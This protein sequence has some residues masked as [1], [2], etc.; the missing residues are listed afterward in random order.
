M[1]ADL[2]PFLDL[3]NFN[4]IRY[5]VPIWQRRYSWTEQTIRQLIKDLVDIS[6]RKNEN[7]NHFGGTLI[8]HPGDSSPGHPPI[9]EVVDGQQRLTTISI[10]LSVIADKLEED[11][12]HGQW[13]SDEIRFYLINQ[14]VP[15]KLKLKLKLQPEDD[16]EYRQIIEGNQPTGNSKITDAWNILRNEVASKTPE[17]LMRGLQRF[18]IIGFKCGEFDDP[19]QIFES[20]N[21]TGDP[22]TEG[23]KVKNWLLMGLDSETQDVLYHDHW[24][25]LEN[26]LEAL[27]NPTNIDI[28]LRDF[29]RW[30]TGENVGKQYTYVNLKRWWSRQVNEYNQDK[31]R[32]CKELSQCAALY[33]TIIGTHDRHNNKDI[34]D[35]FRH[36]KSLQL[37][38]HRP[39]SLRLLDDAT[40]PH[41]TGAHQTELIKVFNAVSIWLT[42]IWLAGVPTSGLNT[43][44]INFAHRRNTQYI[45]SYGDYWIEGIRKLR[46]TR[47]A[48]PNEEEIEKGIKSR[49]AWGEKATPAAKT[50]LYIMNLHYKGDTPPR[51]DDLSLEHIMPQ[52]LSDAWKSYLGNDAS[53]LH[54]E[55][56]NRLANLTLVGKDYNSKI[57]NSPYENKR[58]YYANST[59]MLTKKVAELYED[60]K[61][62]D[63]DY[64]SSELLDLALECWP[65]E[66]VTRA[67]VRWRADNGNWKEERTYASMLLNVVSRLLDLNLEDNSRNLVGDRIRKDIFHSGTEP[68]TGGRFRSIPKYKDYVVNLN[69]SGNY[70]IKLCSKM[71]ERCGVTVDIEKFVEQSNGQKEWE[72]INHEVKRKS[73]ARWR[74]GYSNWEIEQTYTSLL[75]NVIATLLDMDPVRNS[76]CLL[77]KRTHKDLLFSRSEPQG[78]GFRFKKIPRYDQYVI[79]VNRSGSSMIRFCGEIGDRCGVDIQI[80]Q[81]P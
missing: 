60:W 27:S 54:E 1:K 49:K 81:F 10:L 62:D 56:K 30:K 64:R 3:F 9:E 19:Q 28:F 25:K 14:F 77:G 52:K 72:R 46:N 68:E 16:V 21:A 4:K 48:V 12:D 39:F 43:Q 61:A 74:I 20:L 70:I 22:L 59:V 26:C 79:N 58:K 8:T 69:F 66:N 5:T 17:T 47:I 37:N 32:L 57:G 50:I 75:L 45:N 34:D 6:E 80:E 23:E 42:R 18:Q 44:M 78:P 55:Y 11:Q 31:T 35:I 7:S 24:C 41:V 29:L 76:R 36:L 71:G 67:S 51:V 53:E 63:M 33:G 65:W 40:K 13:T 2:I 15:Q 38:I 73:R